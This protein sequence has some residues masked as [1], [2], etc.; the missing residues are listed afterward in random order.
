MSYISNV[1]IR[2]GPWLDAFARL[3]VSEPANLFNSQLQYDLNP[4]IWD[5]ILAGAGSVTHQPNRSSALL[6]NGDTVSG[7]RAVFSSRQYIRYQPGKSQQVFVTFVGGSG[8]TNVVKRVGLFDDHNGVFVQQQSTGLS[9]V[10]RSFVTGVAVEN[11]VAQANWN[12]DRLDGTGPSGITLDSTKAQILFMDLEW[13]GVGEV[14]IGFVIGGDI[15]IAH[16]FNHANILDSVYMSTANLPIRYE[17]INTGV[18]GAVANLEAICSS[19]NSEGGFAEDRAI[20]QAVATPVAL[21]CGTTGAVVLAIRPKLTF[22][23]LTNRSTIAI[24]NAEAVGSGDGRWELYYTNDWTAGAWASVDANGMAEFSINATIGTGSRFAAA[25]LSGT[26]QAR[27]VV[28]RDITNRFPATLGANGTSQW[29]F[30]LV[31]YSVTGSIDVRAA[32][33]WL[34]F[35]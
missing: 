8:T 30:A 26:N 23:G 17:I 29:G 6:S 31:G 14:R 24:D 22:A 32:L 2:S 10:I 25:L 21:S 34:E 20:L 11:T 12:T 15:I 5:S 7:S 13:L 19:V 1:G 27:I 9:F 3:R 4:Y 33:G 28:G 35:R 18:A 16:V